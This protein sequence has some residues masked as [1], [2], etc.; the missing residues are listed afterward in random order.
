M[1]ITPRRKTLRV[2][3]ISYGRSSSGFWGCVARWRFTLNSFLSMS[4][5]WDYNAL[6]HLDAGWHTEVSSDEDYKD[7]EPYWT[8]TVSIQTTVPPN[9]S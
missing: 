5:Q 7:D 2:D 9:C 4:Y 8:Y 1:H 3:R 6:P